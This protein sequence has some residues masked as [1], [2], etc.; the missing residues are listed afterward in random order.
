MTRVNA[1]LA[2]ALL[3][4]ALYLVRLQQASR[5]LYAALDRATS[6]ATR[7]AGETERLRSDISRQSANLRV[8]ALARSRLDM[9]AASPAI[10]AYVRV[11][12]LAASA[13]AR[14]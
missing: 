7:L 6:Q 8:E 10:T 11:P 5:S 12:A 4:S 13:G 1:V 2:L 14:P 9:R 3:A